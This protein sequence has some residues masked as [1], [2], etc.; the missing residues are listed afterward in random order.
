[1][2]STQAKDNTYMMNGPDSY[3]VAQKQPSSRTESQEK[4]S[5]EWSFF[6][7]FPF[8]THIALND[9]SVSVFS[10]DNRCMVRVLRSPFDVRAITW[11]GS[12]TTRP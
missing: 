9:A 8:V 4:A 2:H 12:F 11:N 3:K 10:Q 5:D 7:D 6:C 1:M